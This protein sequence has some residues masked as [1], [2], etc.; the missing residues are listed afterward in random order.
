MITVGMN[1]QV[2]PGKQDAFEEVFQAVLKL[3]QQ[4]PGHT[5]SHLYRDVNDVQRYLIV[6][7]WSDRGAFEQFI[8]SDKFRGVAKWGREQVLA[9]RPAHEI[10][11]H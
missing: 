10:Y 6:S 7:E 11:E 9:G 3:M 5:R 2:L 4:M 1:Y 8:A